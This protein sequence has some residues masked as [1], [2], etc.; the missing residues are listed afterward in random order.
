[1][2]FKSGI[3]VFS[4]LA[5]FGT[6]V[7]LLFIGWG[8]LFGNFGKVFQDIN[9]ENIQHSQAYVQSKTELLL[10]L[11]TSAQDPL[12]TEGQVKATINEFCFQVTLLI[13]SEWSSP[14]ARFE[15]ENCN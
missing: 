9:R 8:I 11:I 10:G 2:V 4:Y 7:L 3:G 5:V 1:L 6:A 13:P 12:A 14:I 15:A